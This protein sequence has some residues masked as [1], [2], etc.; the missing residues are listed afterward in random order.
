MTRI[1]IQGQRADA[2]ISLSYPCN[3]RLRHSVG[4]PTQRLPLMIYFFGLGLAGL[5]LAGLGAVLPWHFFRSALHS[6][7]HCLRRE[8]QFSI[9]LPLALH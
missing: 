8:L 1:P 4:Q 3:P 6:D 9:S 7:S 5:G 2:F